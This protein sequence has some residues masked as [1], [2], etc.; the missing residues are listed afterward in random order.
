MSAKSFRGGVHPNGNKEMSS[1]KPI[2]EFL[3][4]GELVFPLSQHIGKPA[5]PVVKKGDPVLAGQL[6][7]KADGFISAN[8]ISSG[9]GKVKAI[10]P[11][12]TTAGT[13]AQC[14]VIDNDGQFTSVDGYGVPNDVSKMTNKEIIDKVFEAGIV[15]LGGAGFPTHVKLSPRNPE[16]ID[17]I[18]ANGAECEPYITCDHR[19]MVEHPE[20]VLGGLKIVLQLFPEAKGVIAIEDNKP[21]A[22]EAIKALTAG[23]SRIE[24]MPLKTKFPQG[25][26]RNLVHAVTGRKMASGDLPSNLGCI[27]DNVTTLTAIYRA[28]AFNEPLVAK[29]FTVTGD[30]VAEP[31]NFMV[32]IGTN[33]AEL[34]EAAG[35]LKADPKKVIIGGPMMGMAITN[36]NRPIA[37]SYNALL[38]MTEDP[39]E[40]ANNQMTNCIRCGR[41]VRACPVG[42]VPQMLA[43]A[44][45][46]KDLARFEKLHGM[47]CIQCGSCTYICPAKRPLMQMFKVTRAAVMAE[48][49]KAREGKK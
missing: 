25:G 46:R 31:G 29:G 23:E 37:K 20:W 14:I 35:G 19:L 28:V 38:C 30:A 12:M 11:R 7:A 40:Y 3:P 33:I 39:V 43:V 24:V 47:D 17:F 6:I 44:S 34:L 26:E 21:D 45:N 9:S 41:C 13:V 48:R 5:V 49:A 42:L 1:G 32:R 16:D 4:K 8:I 10:E 22:I 2:Q 15:G 18:I 36:L 27:V